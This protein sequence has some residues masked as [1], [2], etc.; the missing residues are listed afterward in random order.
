MKNIQIEEVDIEIS[1][2]DFFEEIRCLEEQLQANRA[3]IDLNR[4][5]T[6]FERLSL[7]MVSYWQTCGST[8]KSRSY[9]L[10]EMD[11][12]QRL[13]CLYI[14]AEIG[15]QKIHFGGEYIC[16]VHFCNAFM[17]N[18][19]VAP[20][21]NCYLLYK[22]VPSILCAGNK[23]LSFFRA[24]QSLSKSSELSCESLREKFENFLTQQNNKEIESLV[25]LTQDFNFKP[26]SS[27]TS[28]YFLKDL[29]DISI[30]VE[31]FNYSFSYK[32][33]ISD[34]G[35]YY[36]SIYSCSIEKNAVT[37]YIN[38]L[39]YS[40]QLPDT[41]EFDII[42][43]KPIYSEYN[44]NEVYAF[45]IR[46]QEIVRYFIVPEYLPVVEVNEEIFKENLSHIPKLKEEFDKIA[47][48]EEKS[49]LNDCILVLDEIK[50]PIY[51]I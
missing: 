49:Y 5:T 40:L 15:G 42:C 21:F 8:I 4:R 29:S 26:C 25:S 1:E 39:A 48:I 6:I 12:E 11:K 3:N 32:N 22:D 23:A 43:S 19:K 47:I 17:K 46:N 20:T 10:K 9:I 13:E 45:I 31:R 27:S 34:S 41:H 36:P 30:G 28:T 35:N 38:S 18:E 51:K 33:L 44:L 24:Y 16:F 7:L 14:A 2:K 37:A 50:S